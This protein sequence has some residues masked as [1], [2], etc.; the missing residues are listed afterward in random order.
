MTKLEFKLMQ[1]NS[2]ALLALLL[3]EMQTN[4]EKYIDIQ[5][6]STAI[7]AIAGTQYSISTYLYKRYPNVAEEIRYIDWIL[8]T[9]L[10][11]YTYWKLANV[12][13]YKSDFMYLGFSVVLMVILGFFAEYTTENSYFLFVLS[14]VPYLYILYEI[15]QIQKMFNDK[16]MSDHATLGNFFIYGWAVYPIAFYAPDTYKYTLYS[17]GDFINKGVYSMFLYKLLQN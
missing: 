16:N 10:L 9:P 5:K 4:Y 2:F 15:K 13:G 17:I 3:N 12:H 7:L 1:I 8:T 6:A 14:F 11:L